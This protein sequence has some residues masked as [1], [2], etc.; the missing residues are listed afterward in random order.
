MIINLGK[1]RTVDVF[2]PKLLTAVVLNIHKKFTPTAYSLIAMITKHPAATKSKKTKSAKA[3]KMKK[4]GGKKVVATKA[5]GR[6]G[7]IKRQVNIFGFVL[8]CFVNS[9]SL[10][11]YSPLLFL[12]LFSFFHIRGE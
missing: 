10:L 2:A 1:K 8:F 7:A 11:S 3:G 4:K 9:V 5:K 6:S 12:S